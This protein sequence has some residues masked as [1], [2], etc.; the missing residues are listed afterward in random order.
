MQIG[1]YFKN[2]NLNHKKHFF[3]GLSFKSSDCK[4]NNIFFAIKGNNSDGSKYIKEAIKKGARTIISNNNFQGIKDQVLF[5]KSDKP[6]ELLSKLSSKIYSQKPKKLVAV[7]G[8]KISPPLFESIFA[9][10]KETTIARLAES[11]EDL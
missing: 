9:L 10:G 5:I 4:K 11:I 8:T 6:R 2:I 7:T 3:S 1:N